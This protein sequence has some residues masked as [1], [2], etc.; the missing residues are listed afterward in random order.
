[1]GVDATIA[2]LQAA[3]YHVELIDA[4]CCGMAGAFGYE[5]EH[6]TL[7]MQIGELKLFPALRSAG[8]YAI[9]A[10]SGASCQAQISDGTNLE[11]VHPIMLIE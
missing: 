9:V 8:K 4:G 11:A 3:G 2:M 1:M 7:S 6:Y 10:A 5:A